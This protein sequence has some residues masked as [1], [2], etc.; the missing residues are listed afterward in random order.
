MCPFALSGVYITLNVSLVEEFQFQNFV[1]LH[2]SHQLGV[3]ALC[4]ALSWLK[5]KYQNG[6]FIFLDGI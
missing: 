5:N 4:M 6:M 1:L 3:L 2:F